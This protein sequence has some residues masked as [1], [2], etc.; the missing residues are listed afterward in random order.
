MSDGTSN[1]GP[2][3][4]KVCDWPLS[5][6]VGGPCPEPEPDL[7]LDWSGEAMR[8]FAKSRGIERP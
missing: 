3:K 2:V 4:C 5:R 1:R 8:A 7:G 6:H